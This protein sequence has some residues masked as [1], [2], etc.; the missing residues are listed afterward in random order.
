MSV[1]G[2]YKQHFN[3][4]R[5]DRP[6]LKSN[7]LQA[8]IKEKGFCVVDLLEDEEVKQLEAGFQE[9]SQKMQADFGEQ[10]WPSGRSKDP[11]IRNLAKK[12]IDN[13]VPEKLKT[14][15]VEDSFEFIGGTYLIKPPSNI[16]SLS[17]HQDSAH[18]NEFE[19]FSV[20][21]WIPL[22][23]VN[24]K[25]GAV[26]VLAKSHQL[27]IKQRS[28]NVP[29]ILEEHKEILEKY[30]QTLEMKAGQALIFDAALIHSSPPNLS[31]KIRVAVNFYIHPKGHPFSHYYTDHETPKGKVEVYSV[32]PEFYYSEDFESKPT[33]KYPRLEDQDLLIDSLSSKEVEQICK[34]L[35]KK[36]ALRQVQDFFT[37][38][39]KG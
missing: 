38:F 37:K 4:E 32:R 1:L 14:L 11:Q 30:M 2:T 3:P 13:V 12:H 29:W 7:E 17:P 8:Q 15:L 16:S 39:I 33:D 23:D 31:Q 19:Y 5:Y 35:T 18:T 36:S 22:Q 20:Y 10:F 6:F 27:D 25:N 26:K 34:N 21:V 9:L 24:V 28:L